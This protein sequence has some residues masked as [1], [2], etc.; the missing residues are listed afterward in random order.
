[1]S[2]CGMLCVMV[3]ISL[4]IGTESVHTVAYLPLCVNYDVSLGYKDVR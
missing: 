4:I 1:M 3:K 2:V